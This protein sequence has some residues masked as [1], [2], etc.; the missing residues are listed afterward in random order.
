MATHKQQ[1]PDAHPAVSSSRLTGWAGRNRRNV[2]YVSLLANLVLCLFLFDPKPHTGGDNAS[3]IILAQ[4][5]LHPGDGYT[6]HIGPGPVVPHT[7]YPFG[8]PLLLAP[9]VALAGVNFVVLKLLSVA[10]SLLS[11]FLFHRIMKCNTTPVIAAAATLCFALNPVL[12]DFSHWVL[13]E[14]AFL[15]FSL[16]ALY[17]LTEATRGGGE[18]RFGRT[19][20]LAVVCLAFTAHIR[21]IGVAFVGGGM[22]YFMV[23]RQWK[24][25]AVFFLAVAALMAPW[26]I[27][28]HLVS[29]ENSAVASAFMMIDPYKP[30]LGT[31]T[32]ADLARRIMHNIS[33]YGGFDSARVVLGSESLWALSVP[34]VFLAVVVSLLVV[35]GLLGRIVKHGMGLLEA[36]FSFFLC[37][38]LVWPDAWSDVRFIMPLIPLMLFY[39]A[40]AVELIVG[41]V[42]PWRKRATVAA[43]VAL[44]AVAALSLSAQVVRIPFNLRML[45]AWSS[46]NRYAGYPPNWRRF[47]EAA[48][49]IRDNT[50]ATAVV[51]SRKPRLVY[52]WSNRRVVGYPFTTDTEAVMAEVT[53]ADYVILD[54][55][56][57]TTDRYLIPALK[58]HQNQFKIV[59][60]TAAPPT[61]VLEV[62]K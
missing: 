25:L 6:Q 21:S 45:T 44:L 24:A 33:T 41:L 51:S 10:F 12:V 31:I 36:Y 59:H 1:T 50:P 34:A 53:Q 30:E 39:L 60:R 16:L 37:I 58:K 26:T 2:L 47:F 62:L 55:V 22:L 43:A 57:G 8:Y 52:L 27:R 48:D 15:C 18:V 3:Y 5:I 13:S 56:S 38:V 20:W 42:R 4:S 9:L 11:V 32:A 40:T 14:E 7:Q 28:N 49:W 29:T 54:N 61:W 46:G 23:R 17:F 19:F 35:T